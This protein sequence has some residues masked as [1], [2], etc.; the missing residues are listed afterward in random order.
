[1]CR[2]PGTGSLARTYTH[3]HRSQ[4]GTILPW[5]GGC[6]CHWMLPLLLIVRNYA[7]MQIGQ[8]S[9]ALFLECILVHT[10]RQYLC[11]P[12]PSDETCLW[13]KQILNLAIIIIMCSTLGMSNAII[14]EHWVS[15]ST[16]CISHANAKYNSSFPFFSRLSN[17]R[18]F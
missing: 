5:S 12:R 10:N 7:N 1:M 14:R 4:C 2:D 8:M 11:H 15:V 13:T 18:H 16:G 17:F 6:R 9:G 3:A